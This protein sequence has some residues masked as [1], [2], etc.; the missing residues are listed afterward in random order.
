VVVVGLVVVVGVVVVVGLVVVVGVVAM[1]ARE[2]EK[3]QPSENSMPH[4][5]H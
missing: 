2:G 1:C 3:V 5:T 4:M